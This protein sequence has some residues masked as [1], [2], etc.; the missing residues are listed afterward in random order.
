[1]TCIKN[2]AIVTRAHAPRQRQRLRFCLADATPSRSLN[3]SQ[4]EAVSP[5]NL[6]RM[7]DTLPSF[8][9]TMRHLD[10]EQVCAADACPLPELRGELLA[11]APPSEG[12]D[13]RRGYPSFVCRSEAGI[14]ARVRIG[15]IGCGSNTSKTK[16]DRLLHTPFLDEVFGEDSGINKTQGGMLVYCNGAHVPLHELVR[17]GLG[18]VVV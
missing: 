15:R 14:S 8:C 11:V 10:P 18:H 13:A 1:V 9:D 3:G 5:E 7:L 17:F 12:Y 16:R 6:L 4:I 2:R